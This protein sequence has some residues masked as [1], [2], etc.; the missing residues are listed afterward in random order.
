MTSTTL[1]DGTL[2]VGRVTHAR[3]TPRRH[4]FGYRAFYALFD[5]DRIDG[6]ASRLR[7]LS[8]NRANLL[9]L[10]D[11]DHLGAE[12]RPLR[13][14]ADAILAQAG[15][16]LAGGR[17]FLLC[18]PRLLGFVFNPISVYFCHDADAALVCML[19]EVNNT[20]GQRHTYVVPVEGEAQAVGLVR[21]TCRKV[22][23]V[24]PF[25]DMDLTYAFRLRRPDTHISIG[26]TASR[27]DA[28]VIR[29]LFAGRREELTDRAILATLAAH[30]LMTLKVIGA[31][32]WEALRLWLKGMRVKPRPAA[33]AVNVSFVAPKDGMQ[34]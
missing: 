33:P 23:Y 2:Y 32:H 14:K 13:E 8:R 3:M 31:I 9:S 16:D 34:P 1:S 6:V 19:Y 5:L 30:P 24:S 15:V 10:H 7:F 12:R 18:M 20:F 25:M 26:I 22:L 27:G 4:A 28:P 11:V 29:T 17:I 21:Q